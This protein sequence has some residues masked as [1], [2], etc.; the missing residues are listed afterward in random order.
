MVNSKSAAGVV[1]AAPSHGETSKRIL[2]FCQRSSEGNAVL[3]AARNH[4]PR[5]DQLFRAYGQF[6]LFT[7]KKRIQRG[8]LLAW[9]NN[10]LPSRC[11]EENREVSPSHGSI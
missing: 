4:V 9:I 7:G 1:S 3:L 6:C 11:I 8:K 2:S 5:G 10:D